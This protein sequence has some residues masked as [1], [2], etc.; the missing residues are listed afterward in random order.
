M[1]VDLGPEL[2][3]I[4]HEVE[5]KTVVIIDENDHESSYTTRGS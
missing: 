5:G 2:T 4:V 1:H 3:E